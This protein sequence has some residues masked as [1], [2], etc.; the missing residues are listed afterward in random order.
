MTLE[1]FKKLNLPDAPG[2]YFFK[3]ARGHI[4]YIGRATSLRDRVRSYFNND[5]IHTRGPLIV[6]MVTRGSSLSHTE[7]DSVLEAVILEANLIKKHQPPANIQEKDDKSFNYIVITRE[8]FPRVLLVRGRNVPLEYPEKKRLY[9]IGPFPHGAVL[10]DALKI[11]RKLFP[12][13]DRCVPASELMA[14]GKTPKACFNHQLGL[15]PGVCSGEMDKASYR[16]LIKHL[17]LFLEGKKA[18]L[19]RTLEKEMKEYAKKKEFERASAVKA[20]LQALSHIHDIALIKQDPSAVYSKSGFRMEAYDIAHL[21]GESMAGAM[22]VSIDGE[23][24]KN[25][26]RR[27]RIYGFEDAHDVGAL[28]EVLRRRFTHEEWALPD[29]IVLDGAL[30]QRNAAE[31]VLKEYNLAIPLVSVVKN[32]RHRPERL[33][34]RVDMIKKYE[35]EILSLN[36][37]VHRFAIAY[38]KQLRRKKFLGA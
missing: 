2:V 10:K 5:V 12:F 1:D 26:Y 35:K 25:Y 29:L 33:E 23:F 30:A 38:H 3:D 31:K 15:C 36:Q 20:T 21:S 4:L 24:A 27:F 19:L 11:I 8:D 28:A 37:E 9:L 13:R 7:T 17:A 16:K 34:G 18:T 14:R 32:E 22:V 6:D